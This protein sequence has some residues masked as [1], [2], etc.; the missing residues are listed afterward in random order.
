[1]NFSEIVKNVLKQRNDTI[2]MLAEQMGYSVQYVSDLLSGRR[3][4][5]ETTMNKACEVLGIKVNYS[6]SDKIA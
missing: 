6:I 2:T 5:N 1:V 3:R 4:W